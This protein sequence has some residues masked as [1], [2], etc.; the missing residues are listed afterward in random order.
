MRLPQWLSA[1][2]PTCH[3]GATGDMGSIPGL[4]ISP[5]EG[6]SNLLQCSCWENPHRQRS[7]A[8]YSPYSHKESDRTEMT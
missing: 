8:G 7:L 4:G 5:G 6:H 1:K 2:E 3:A